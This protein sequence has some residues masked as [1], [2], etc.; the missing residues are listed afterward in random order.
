MTDFPKRC[1]VAVGDLKTTMVFKY[2]EQ[3]ARRYAQEHGLTY[4]E[5]DRGELRNLLNR[6]TRGGDTDSQTP[7]TARA[8]SAGGGSEA[9]SAGPGDFLQAVN[10]MLAKGLPV[11]QAIKAAARAWPDLFAAY[12]DRLP[13]PQGF[14]EF[15]GLAESPAHQGFEAEVGKLISTGLTRMEAIVKAAHDFPE[16]HAAY[17]AGYSE[18]LAGTFKEGG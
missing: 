5:M 17:I 6:L 2:D 8:A 10:R 3:A 7:L 12:K 16:L 13:D 15:A 18:P 11:R 9:G 14:E 4:R 1:Y